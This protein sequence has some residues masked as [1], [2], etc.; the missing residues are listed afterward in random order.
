MVVFFFCCVFLYSSSNSGGGGGTTGSGGGSHRNHRYS[1]T[2]SSNDGF[3]VNYG[4]RE[5]KEEPRE[6][7]N[8]NVHHSVVEQGDL[9]YSISFST[10]TFFR[11]VELRSTI[12]SLLNYDLQF[13]RSQERITP[14]G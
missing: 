3:E 10:S 14:S 7:N 5:V 13:R 12:L 9:P 1:A 11:V 8:A 6:G 4:D 2:N